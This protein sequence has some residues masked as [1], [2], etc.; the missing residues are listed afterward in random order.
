MK[1]EEKTGMGA[2]PQVIFRPSSE[3]QGY[4]RFHYGYLASDG[5]FSEAFE[6][7]FSEFLDTVEVPSSFAAFFAEK[8]NASN[9]EVCGFG[10]LSQ[11]I[12]CDFLRWF[13]SSCAMVQLYPGMLV[14]TFNKEEDEG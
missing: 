8:L 10:Y 9:L 7:S 12:F 11:D 6:L 5:A 3:R 1:T 4:Y 2:V 13:A 14:L